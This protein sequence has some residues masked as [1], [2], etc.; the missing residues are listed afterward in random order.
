MVVR[1]N[2][3][4]ERRGEISHSQNLNSIA[5][6][7]RYDK[8]S[9]SVDWRRRGICVGKITQSTARIILQ[10]CGLETEVSMTIGQSVNQLIIS[11]TH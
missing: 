8:K 6:K 5:D 7:I 11:K 2:S 3:E 10:Q 1:G 4:V 9:C